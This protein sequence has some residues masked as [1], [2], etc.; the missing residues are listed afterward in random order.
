MRTK[1]KLS[2]SLARGLLLAA[3]LTLCLFVLA[4]GLFSWAVDTFIGRPIEAAGEW[5]GEIEIQD[6]GGDY[7]ITLPSTEDEAR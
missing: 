7:R 4:Y 5:I 2:R 3:T 6:R 1:N